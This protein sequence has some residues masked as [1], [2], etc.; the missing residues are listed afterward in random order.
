MNAG[1]LGYGV[2][3]AELAPSRVDVT[4]GIAHALVADDDDEEEDDD[5]DD[6]DDEDDDLTPAELEA[7]ERAQQQ[8]IRKTTEGAGR[9]KF[10]SHTHES[11]TYQ[12]DPTFNEIKAQ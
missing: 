11:A 4:D 5:D 1:T 10:H 2:T 3:I 9:E 7:E 6:Q 8:A 12:V